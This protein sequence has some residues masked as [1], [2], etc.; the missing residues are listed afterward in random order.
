MTLAADQNDYYR[1]LFNLRDSAVCNMMESPTYLRAAF[2]ELTLKEAQDVAEFWMLNCVRIEKDL[3]E[4]RK[5]EKN[6]SGLKA[7]VKGEICE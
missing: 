5:P 4:A 1:F 2:P 3:S 7:L 6:R